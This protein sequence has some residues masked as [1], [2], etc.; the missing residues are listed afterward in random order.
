MNFK[1]TFASLLFVTL[2]PFTNLSAQQLTSNSSPYLSAALTS[3]PQYEISSINNWKIKGST[4]R[5]TGIGFFA[6]GIAVIS[7]ALPW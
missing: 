4:L 5:N 7:V 3:K 1:N 6:F 2:L